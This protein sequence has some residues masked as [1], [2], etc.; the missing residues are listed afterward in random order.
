MRIASLLRLD[1]RRLRV[2]TIRH[3][4]NLFVKPPLTI[5]PAIVDTRSASWKRTAQQFIERRRE[6]THPTFCQRG[7]DQRTEEVTLDEVERV[8]I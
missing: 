4:W 3:P 6:N 1:R 5:R 7:Y 8:V 2:P